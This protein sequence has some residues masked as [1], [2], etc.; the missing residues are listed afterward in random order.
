M[1]TATAG[2]AA[3]TCEGTTCT[4]E[5]AANTSVGPALHVQAAVDAC[6]ASETCTTVVIPAGTETWDTQV[7]IGTGDIPYTKSITITGQSNTSPTIT[8][9]SGVRLFVVVLNGSELNFQL[10]K[11]GLVGNGPASDA[12]FLLDGLWAKARINDI[13]W[14]GTTSHVI[15]IGWNFGNHSNRFFGDKDIQYEKVLI[16]NIT[17]TTSPNKTQFVQARGLRN[18]TW[19]R[20]DN[21]GTDDFIFIE[22]CSLTWNLAAGQPAGIVIDT[23]FGGVRY[24]ARYNTI[25]NGW[26]SQH[27]YG[28]QRG[29]RLV[30]IY[31]NSMTANVDDAYALNMTRGGTGIAHHNV[32]TGYEHL[33]NPMIYRVG[34]NNAAVFPG[35]Y[36]AETGSLKTCHDGVRHCVGGTKHG[37]PCY[38]G[39]GRCAEGGGTCNTALT[40][41]SNDDCKDGQGNTIICMQ[42][43]GDAENG[44]PCRDQAGRGKDNATTGV[45]ES[46]PIYWYSNTVDGTP[47]TAYSV[48]GYG[49]YLSENV[50]YCN[51]DPSTDCGTKAA[52]TYTAYTCPHP[53]ATE[54]TGYVCT[55]TTAGR[56]GYPGTLGGVSSYPT[57]KMSGSTHKWSGA[58]A[59]WQ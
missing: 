45:Q 23:D 40:C 25:V 34:W 38:T 8:A 19:L 11:L 30:E 31:N 36:C 3:P 33:N 52:W 5:S 7:N 6:N 58:T 32:I 56:G 46:S 35:Y 1:L 48:G 24:T 54:Y 26:F 15:G 41:T 37:Y 4:S 51:H 29:N 13:T 18:I 12:D 43:D 20:D 57:H 22:N 14:T 39:D 9:A 42:V 53:W 59:V 10:T 28:N 16:D 49:A 2:Y 21:Y 27:D 44:Y 47:N 55:T 17:Y 50:D